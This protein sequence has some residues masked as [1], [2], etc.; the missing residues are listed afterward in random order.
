MARL[1]NKRESNITISVIVDGKD[2]KWYVEKVKENYP[3]P[4]L[5]SIRIDPQLPQKKKIKELFSLAKTKVNEGYSHVILLIDFDE[6]NKNPN[7]F[8]AFNDLYSKYQNALNNGKS[9]D[10]M[11]KITVIVNNPCLEYWYLLHFRNTTK[12]YSKFDPDLKNDLRKIA[13]L[14]DYEKSEDY[15]NKKPDIYSRLNKSGGLA[16]ARSNAKSFNISTCRSEGCSEMKALFDLFDS[17]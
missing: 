9:K 5:K 14:S 6:P 17:L 16:K 10:W 13:D 15:Y 12:F 7:E 8:N 1:K 11:T 3:C 2:E 4:N